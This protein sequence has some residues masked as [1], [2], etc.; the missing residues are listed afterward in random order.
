MRQAID[1]TERRRK[2]QIEYNLFNNID[3][4]NTIREI[5]EDLINLDYGL[6]MKDLEGVNIREF[7]NKKDIEKEIK[8]L[9]KE[10]E[11]LSS[12]LNFE[13]AIKKRD[14]MKKLQKLI[15]DF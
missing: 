9:K 6:P 10:I 15:L 7:S 14:E 13:L 5:S 4:K 1:E 3:P 11:V 2:R 8:N 12:E